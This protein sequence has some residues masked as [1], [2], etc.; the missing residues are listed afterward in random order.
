MSYLWTRGIY[1]QCAPQRELL[2]T[3]APIKKRQRG[4]R[5]PLMNAG[6]GSPI[7]PATS[8][9]Y[10]QA[11]HR[12]AD[13]PPDLS[14]C[15][16]QS[17]RRAME[18]IRERRSTVVRRITDIPA[19]DKLNEGSERGGSRDFFAV[20]V[21]AEN[22]P[23]GAI[24]HLLLHARTHDERG[25]LRGLFGGNRL[26]GAIDP[27]AVRQDA[28]VHVANESN[29]AGHGDSG[30][31]K[32]CGVIRGEA[33]ALLDKGRD[34]ST[35]LQPDRLEGT[36][37]FSTCVDNGELFVRDCGSHPQ[38]FHTGGGRNLNF[39][40]ARGAEDGE[41]GSPPRLSVRQDTRAGRV[42]H[43]NVM[44][45]TSRKR[46]AHEYYD[47]QSR[48]SSGSLECHGAFHRTRCVEARSSNRGDT[49]F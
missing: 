16:T 29:P 27:T 47:C 24:H 25:E 4:C 3:Q 26:R 20:N 22:F 40:L 37:C 42:R 12:A 19:L 30:V 32:N 46:K 23:C 14:N 44:Q 13:A 8:H 38:Q 49:R 33:G 6:D 45:D 28:A 11:S 5:T 18:L 17:S 36:C 41:G 35:Y 9:H 21:G 7:Q 48:T 43:Y 34:E 15:P 10:A 2:T 1:M 31:T 39:G